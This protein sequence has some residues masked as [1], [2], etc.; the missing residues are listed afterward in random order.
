MKT[1]VSDLIKLPPIDQSAQ[2]TKELASEWGV[3]NGTAIKMV[4]GLLQEGRIEV[5]RKIGTRGLIVAYRPK[6]K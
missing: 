3:A 4:N 2:S 5:V 1:K 6:V